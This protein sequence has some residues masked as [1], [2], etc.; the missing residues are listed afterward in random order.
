MNSDAF[1]LETPPR[2]S[3]PE[4]AQT[5]RPLC[6][7]GLPAPHIQAHSQR[8]EKEEQTNRAIKTLHFLPGRNTRSQIQPAVN[9]GTPRCC[10]HILAHLLRIPAPEKKAGMSYLSCGVS[11]TWEPHTQASEPRQQLSKAHPKQATSQPPGTGT[12][13]PAGGEGVVPASSSFISWGATQRWG[14][15]DNECEQLCLAPP[16]CPPSPW[17]LLEGLS[18]GFGLVH[19][20]T[21]CSGLTVSPSSYLRPVW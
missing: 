21:S 5:Q 12:T 7:R 19:Q 16:C 9:A 15:H 3:S 6:C 13:H 17:P 20:R 2:S 14:P 8:P 18:S 4:E 11:H 1:H 10:S